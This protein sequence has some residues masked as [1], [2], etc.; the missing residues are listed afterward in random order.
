[1]ETFKVF[2]L[3]QVTVSAFMFIIDSGMYLTTTTKIKLH[4][5]MFAY[6]YCDFQAQLGQTQTQTCLEQDILIKLIISTCVY[7]KVSSWYCVI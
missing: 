7:F 1:M 3:R 6:F 5:L 4:F 2:M